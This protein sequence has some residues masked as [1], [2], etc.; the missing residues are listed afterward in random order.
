MKILIFT[1]WYAPAYKAG[2]PVRSVVNMVNLL[3][4][5]HEVYVFTKDRDLKD[6]K[7]FRDI[8]ED[9]WME[10]DGFSIYH[11]SPGKMT[12][13]IVRKTILEIAPDRIYLN[14]MF[15]NMIL[16]MMVAGK[17]GNVI[18]CTRGMLR[19]SALSVKWLKKFIYL[20]VLKLWGMDK[21][22][23][24]HA[25]SKQESKDIRRVFPNAKKILIA[26]NLPESVLK[27]LPNMEK[28]KGT[29]NMVFVG[30]M[31]P[32]KNLLFL[33]EAMGRVNGDIHFDIV[34]T[35]EDADYWK[36]CKKQIFKMQSRFHIVTY[37]DLKHEKV[38]A[39]LMKAHLFVLP[40]EGENFGHAIFEA[41]AVGCPILIS[42]QTPWR[43]LSEKKAGVDL[44]LS[45][46][47]FTHAMQYFVDMEDD[48]WQ[49]Y[50]KGALAVAAD[51]E[52]NMNS[53]NAYHDLFAL[54]ES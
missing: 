30:R 50:R 46:T 16:P 40:T 32:I 48:S 4:K 27:E 49:Q 23:T 47:K 11:Y 35:R 42:D 44:S 29:L 54:S 39:M 10:G 9:E 34:A 5:E 12:L 24:F 26:P 25:T 3:K 1:D 53:L 14:S 33:L 36:K 19:K 22:L 8:D 51:Y 52:K 15:S 20:T 18:L 38:R 2:G 17:S 7:P 31:H 21:C 43:N 6:T 45:R 28:Q 37:A 41:L 13:P